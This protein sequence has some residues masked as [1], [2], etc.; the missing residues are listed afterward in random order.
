MRS[1]TNYRTSRQGRDAGRMNFGSAR[2]DYGDL[3][4]GGR[5]N[6]QGMER[7]WWDH[8]SDEVSSWLGGDTGS[9]DE[10][11][12]WHGGYN[13]TAQ[14]QDRRGRYSSRDVGIRSQGRGRLTDLRAGDVMTRNV[15][16]VHLN[17]TVRYAARLMRDEDFGALPVVDR[18]GRMIGMITDRDITVRL[19]AD[20]YEPTH[21]FVSDCM[22]DD[23]FACHVNDPLEHC[24]RAM[25]EHQIR[26][27]P[28]VNNDGR[29]IGIIA[30]ADI[31][32]HA[33]ENRGRGGRRAVS[34]VVC[35]ISEPTSD[36]YNS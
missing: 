12:Y 21:A 31:A 5:L 22:T 2:S 10:E 8:T 17:D 24:M 30:Q 11:R 27:I 20:G 13:E 14:G 34:D 15:S 36:A 28:V 29:V 26:R 3:A 18:R 33:G 35:A 6:E 32:H 9:G 19:V 16:T 1:D 7:G 23:V 4:Y 25:A